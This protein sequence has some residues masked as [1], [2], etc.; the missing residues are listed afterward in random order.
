MVGCWLL[1]GQIQ[2][3]RKIQLHCRVQGYAMSMYESQTDWNGCT[4][5][6]AAAVAAT[7]MRG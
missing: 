2:M 5:A 6:V 3:S 4:V 7:E 1:V